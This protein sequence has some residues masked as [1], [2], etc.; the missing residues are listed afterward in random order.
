LVGIDP[1]A[2]NSPMELRVKAAAL[3]EAA[4]RLADE[5]K[6]ASTYN[7]CPYT[8][9]LATLQR[10][11]SIF[12]KHLP[13]IPLASDRGFPHSSCFETS[14][15]FVTHSMAQASVIRAHYTLAER[16]YELCRLNGNVD[17]T[18]MM[19][20]NVPEIK[21]VQDVFERLYAYE[22]VSSQFGMDN[23]RLQ[24]PTLQH[25]NDNA[26]AS[27]AVAA[28]DK[29]LVA[30]MEIA[31]IV[32]CLAQNDYTFLEPVVGSC[33]MLAALVILREVD[34]INA[35]QAARGRPA[36]VSANQFDEKFDLMSKLDSIVGALRSLGRVFPIVDT[37][38]QKISTMLASQTQR[39]AV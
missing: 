21:G 23:A 1:T 5:Q 10:T 31:R 4:A 16:A 18:T 32:S 9:Q 28:L 22:T 24:D 35:Q 13:P 29:C 2:T 30:A 8:P 15:I 11:I 3:F 37:Q 6:P 7:T 12:T 14:S 26:S 34:R 36:D 33:W 38:A 17:A 39:T 20:H 25:M 27:M 19:Y